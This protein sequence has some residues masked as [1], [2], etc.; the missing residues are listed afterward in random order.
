MSLQ[1][2]ATGNP[3]FHALSKKEIADPYLVI[4]E[5]FDFADLADAREL[6]WDWLKTTVTGN[7][8]KTLSATERSTILTLYEKMEKLLEAAYVLQECRVSKTRY[9]LRHKKSQ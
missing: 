2:D 1:N 4:D 5:L 6:L 8:H 3:S 7:Y 9:T